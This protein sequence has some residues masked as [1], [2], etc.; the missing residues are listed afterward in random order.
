MSMSALQGHV[1]LVCRR[2]LP[3]HPLESLIVPIK[4]SRENVSEWVSGA[5]RKWFQF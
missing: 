3:K 4:L 1:I 2:Q 5:Q